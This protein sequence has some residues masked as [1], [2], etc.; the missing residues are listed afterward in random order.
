LFDELTAPFRRAWDTIQDIVNKIKNAL[1]FTKRHS[2]SVLD[3]VRSGV[4]QVNK[5]LEGLTVSPALNPKLAFAGVTQ[6]NTGINNITIS[7][8]G[9]YITDFSQATD[10][11]ERIGDSIIKKLQ[12]NVKF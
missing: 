3:I 4:G 12:M 8:A 2:P 1:D 10:L 9:A 7:L 5:A 6:G 11:G